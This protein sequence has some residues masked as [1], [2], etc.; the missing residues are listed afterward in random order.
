M[1]DKL[2]KLFMM[3]F[4]IITTSFTILM[5]IQLY[6]FFANGI[7]WMPWYNFLWVTITP[8]LGYIMMLIGEYIDNRN[9]NQN[10]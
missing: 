7:T 6:N 8:L 4:V 9:N 10:K 1:E 2:I 5:I 3:L